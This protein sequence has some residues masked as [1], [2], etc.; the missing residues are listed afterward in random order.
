MSRGDFVWLIGSFCQINR[1]PFDSAL[2]LQRFPA[3]HSMRQL[4][5][6]LRSLGFRTGEGVLSRAAFPCIAFLNNERPA[7]VIKAD[8]AELL[9]VEAGS[10]APARAASDRFEARALLLR[11]ERSEEQASGRFGFRWF[12]SEL[13]KHER[14]WRDVLLASLF[15]QL[16]GLTTPLFTQVI[17]DKVVVHQTGSTLVAIAVGLVMFL[18]FNAAMGWLRQYLVLHTGNRVDAVLGSQVFRHLLRLHLPYFEHRPT[19]TLIARVH[20][21][22]TIREFMAGAAA[23][24]VLDFP[25][26]LIFV[27]VM[28]AYSWQLTLIA[29]GLLGLVGAL[30]IAVVP[31]LRARIN[32]Q[33]LLGARNQAFLTEYVAGMETV[34][35]LQMEPRLE[36]RYD[37]L[38]ATYLSAG[39]AT[40][41]LSNTYNT[42]ANALE[43]V[44]TLAILVVGALLVMRNDGFTIGMLVAFQMFASRMSQPML[45]L[46]GLWQEFQQASIAVKRLGDIMDAPA[47]PYALLPSRS[48]EGKGE[49]RV[50]DVSFRYSS[51]HPVLYR[52]L[53][54]ALKPGRLTVLTGPSGSGKSTLAKLLLGFYQPTEGAITIDGR[55]LRHL[56]AN[57]LRQCFGVVP[58]ET[59]LFSGSI[60][61]NLLAA[62]PN[63]SFEQ[64]QQACR[65]AEIHDFIEK[66]PQGY[67]TA[68]GEHGVGLSGGQKQRLAI[69]RAVLK[70]PRVLIFD[71]AASNLDAQTAERFAQTVN[72]LKGKVTIL[73][74]A[75]QLP[76]GLQVDEVFTLNAEKATQMRVVDEVQT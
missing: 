19:G 25:F 74:I 14:V 6:A 56:S 20:A 7:I 59:Y 47:E 45:R 31:L 49:I 67:N 70:R 39:F 75:H 50:A 18:V 69:A 53:S 17:I 63:A 13:L 66:L 65:I 37:E 40:R 22:E 3:P 76:R 32:H 44:M 38:L 64:V 61:E 11:H 41:Q 34:K 60:Y 57:E 5:E 33:F 30:S 9:Y 28:F 16:I 29:L 26:L 1:L 21:V 10:Q 54:L 55:D 68:L 62:N 27:A 43:Q 36:S 23:S 46:A 52:N 35:S 58:Q 72:Q 42:V 2:L 12:W 48:A 4:L 71:E 24:L 73:F 8:G 51:D 15:I